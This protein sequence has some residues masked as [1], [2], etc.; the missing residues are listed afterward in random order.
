MQSIL[1]RYKLDPSI[2]TSQVFESDDPRS[3]FC[4]IC[5]LLCDNRAFLAFLVC[6][7]AQKMRDEE[8][9][10]YPHNLDFRGRA[11]PMH[12]HL[13]HLSS[14]LCR[15]VLEF[16]EGRPLGKSGLQ[17]LKIHLANLYAGGIEKLSYEDRVAFVENH[18]DDISD[19]ARNPISGERWWL[20]AEDPFQC[21]AAC[22]DLSKAL[23]SSSPDNVI[24]HLPIHLVS[25]S[26][27]LNHEFMIYE[28]SIAIPKFSRFC[29]TENKG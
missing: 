20:T 24:S 18:L 4:F 13:N 15:G 21:L 19:S 2:L 3:C 16:G 1:G 6:Q 28:I 23:S 26:K 7:V 29:L 25:A 12:P 27:V 10:Y 22:I 11:Y 14:D 8:G 17:W 5:G 9:F